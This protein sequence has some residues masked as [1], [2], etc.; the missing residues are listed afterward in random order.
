M[1]E[2]RRQIELGEM[3]IRRIELGEMWIRTH[4]NNGAHRM[5]GKIR[6]C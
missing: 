4:S 5:H 1:A 2:I 3:W 6:K